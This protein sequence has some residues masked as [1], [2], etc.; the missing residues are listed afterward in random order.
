[1]K[2]ILAFFARIFSRDT[3]DKILKGLEAAAPYYRKALEVVETIAALTPDRTDDQIVAVLKRFAS[4]VVLGST[5]DRSALLRD[6]AVAALR[7]QFPEAADRQLNRAIEVA[8]GA[9]K[10]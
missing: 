6:V 8:L 3:S 7:K 9:V 5:Q 1:M 10:P 4:P 2:R